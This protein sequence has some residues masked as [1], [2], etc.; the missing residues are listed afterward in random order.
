MKPALQVSQALQVLAIDGGQSA[1]GDCHSNAAD[2]PRAS[3][4]TAAVEVHGVS[5]LEGDVIG[6]VPKAVAEGWRR[7]G[8][9]PTDRDVRG[10]TTAPT[11]HRAR[12]RLCE[13]IAAAIPVREVWLADDAVTAHA[14]ALS[15]RW[16]S[17]IT[18]GTGVLLGRG[19]D[20]GRYRELVYV[21]RAAS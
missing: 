3:D 14:G 16:G 21:W 11:D 19:D 8:A 9:P 6:S 1:I 7:T 13:A 10:L 15:L 5:R 20:P 18:V 17:S 12:R 2:T 4:A